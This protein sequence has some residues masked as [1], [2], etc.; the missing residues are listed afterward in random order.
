MHCACYSFV[1]IDLT[2]LTFPVAVCIQF[3]YFTTDSLTYAHDLI[4]LTL[5]LTKVGNA[6]LSGGNEV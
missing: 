6:V 2:C 4:K 5:T 1:C 3:E